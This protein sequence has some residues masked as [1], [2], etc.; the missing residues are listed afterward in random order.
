MQLRCESWCKVTFC[1]KAGGACDGCPVCGA[2]QRLPPVHLS[3]L[4]PVRKSPPLWPPPPIQSPIQSPQPPKMAA[5]L[6]SLPAASPNDAFTELPMVF[7]GQPFLAY[8]EVVA[9][10]DGGVL[11]GAVGWA[12]GVAD[13]STNPAPRAIPM[14][15]GALPGANSPLG[16]TGGFAALMTFGPAIHPAV[17]ASVVLCSCCCCV[18]LGLCNGLSWFRGAPSRPFRRDLGRGAR[19]RGSSERTSRASTRRVQP[20]DDRQQHVVYDEVE[21]EEHDDEEENDDE[22]ALEVEGMGRSHHGCNHDQRP[23]PWPSSKSQPARR[24]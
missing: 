19:T 17:L 8:D 3:P 7:A 14:T 13:P 4:P 5:Q 9:S 18:G 20:G 6:F 11:A 16:N 10:I 12:P 2:P 22:N 21:E 23:T 15:T 24:T 1:G